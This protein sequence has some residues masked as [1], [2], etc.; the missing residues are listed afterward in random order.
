MK[1]KRKKT[2]DK[3]ESVKEFTKRIKKA[4]STLYR[5]YEKNEELWLETKFKNRKRYIPSH[6]DRYFNS[7]IMY[8]EYKLAMQE[9][10]SMRNLIDQ[11]MDRDSLPTTFW[12]LDWSFFVTVAYKADRNQ[13]S[14]FR[15]MHALY[16]HLV[17]KYGGRTQIRIF[18]STEP[19]ADR[20]GYHNHL[21]LYLSDEKLHDTI[22]KEVDRFFS[23][24]RV[25]FKPYD[26]YKAGIFYIAKEGL[27]LDDW[28]IMFDDDKLRKQV[29]VLLKVE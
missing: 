15:Q 27:H 24:D 6:H 2:F 29:D 28:D 8:D 22:M 3:I 12:Y 18:F 19:F 9:N 13:T 21:A 11:L 5:F 7:E 10:K 17:K 25:G 4:K 20:K 23:F 14:C 16:D 26:R 1:A